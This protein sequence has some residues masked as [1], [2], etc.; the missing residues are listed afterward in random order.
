MHIRKNCCD[1]TY[2][3]ATNSA[4]YNKKIYNLIF[5]LQTCIYQNCRY[6]NKHKK[7]VHA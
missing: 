5:S 1:C 3:Y 2:K 6:Q 4:N 7:K